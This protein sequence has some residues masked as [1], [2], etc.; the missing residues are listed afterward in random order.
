MRGL[1]F[2]TSAVI[3]FVSLLVRT[4][5][6]RN[7]EV[8]PGAEA[9]FIMPH[10]FFWI[11]GWLLMSANYEPVFPLLDRVFSVHL[12]LVGP[13]L[14]LGLL[15]LGLLDAKHQKLLFHASYLGLVILAVG[16]AW[17]IAERLMA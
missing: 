1:L 14:F 12:I 4:V 8:P 15:A 10:I 7:R 17:Y 16:S 2:A 3:W 9:A 6:L 13:S 11:A 5:L